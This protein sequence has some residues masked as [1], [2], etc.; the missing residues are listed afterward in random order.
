[1]TDYGRAVE[2]GANADP[3]V[4]RPQ[5][6]ALVLQHGLDTF[7]LWPPDDPIRQP[8]VFARDVVPGVREAVARERAR[9]A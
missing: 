1:M 6:A 9:P 8:E 2:F 7:I 4:D 3:L 5:L